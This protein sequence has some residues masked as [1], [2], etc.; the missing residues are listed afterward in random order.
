MEQKSTLETWVHIEH[1][2]MN[3]RGLIYVKKTMTGDNFRWNA[4][5]LMLG[6]KDHTKE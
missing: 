5:D 2:E 1:A 3:W 4:T 6:R